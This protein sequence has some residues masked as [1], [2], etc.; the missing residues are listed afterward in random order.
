MGKKQTDPDRNGPMDSTTLESTPLKKLYDAASLILL[1]LISYTVYWAYS[2]L[3]ERI[4]T[5]FDLTGQPDGFGSR[6][7]IIVL[8]ALTWI[9]NLAFYAFIRCLPRMKRNP[10]FINIPHKEE[11]LKLPEQKQ[12]KYWALLAEF[13]AG[14]PACLNLLMYCT[15]RGITDVALGEAVRLPPMYVWPAIG[16]LLLLPVFYTVRLF[17]FMGKLLRGEA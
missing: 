17:T 14:I 8:A 5:H 4:P 7:S 2:R 6:T 10:R 11:F 3:P 15:L 13:M 1:L 12:S 16:L 9:I